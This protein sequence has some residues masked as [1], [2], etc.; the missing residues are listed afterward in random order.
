MHIKPGDIFMFQAREKYGVI[1]VI[2]KSKYSGY[3]VRVFCDLIDEVNDNLID[4]LM[5]SER[6]YFI[7]D[8]YSNDLTKYK[9]KTS[10]H[11]GDKI[12]M[13]KYMR[14]SE[15]K[16]NG[17]I[18]WY[19]FDVEKGIIVEKF[20]KFNNKLISLSPFETWGIEY[21]EK[22]WAE[23]FD[24]EKW[25]DKLLDT[26]YLNYLKKYEPEKIYKFNIQLKKNS[27]L[28]KWNKENRISKE[29]FELLEKLFDEFTQNISK[30][31]QLNIDRDKSLKQLILDINRIND[32]FHFLYTIESEELIEF[33]NYLLSINN[34]IDENDIIDTY[35]KW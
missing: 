21:I 33:I 22:R 35:R 20:N 9:Y 29:I 30:V 15:R 4:E 12:H 1:Q 6:F 7:K 19:I 27:P 16:I 28:K 17:N 3:N 31:N 14:A 26:W 8:F 5:Q 23:N 25:N 34:I 13:P 2:E 32:K 24:L 11:I 18:V 10:R